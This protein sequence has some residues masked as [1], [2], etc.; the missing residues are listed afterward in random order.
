MTP[1]QKATAY[2][3][4]KWP[5]VHQIWWR[6]LIVEAVL[7]GYALKEEKRTNDAIEPEVEFEFDQ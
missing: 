3:E 1:E 4:K 7:F 6:S 2:A 5:G